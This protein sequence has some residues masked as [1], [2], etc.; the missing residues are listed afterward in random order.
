[1]VL[2]SERYRKRELGTLDCFEMNSSGTISW[3]EVADAATTMFRVW[4]SGGE[5][6]WAK[7]C[8]MHFEKAGLTSGADVV[9][10]T[11]SYLRLVAL[12]HIYEE[13]SSYMWDENPGT[14]LSDLAEDLEINAIALGVI[15]SRDPGFECDRIDDD[16]TLHEHVLAAVIDQLRPEIHCCLIEAYG[17]E[18]ALYSRMAKTTENTES[19]NS[20]EEFSPTG[21]HVRAWSFVSNAFQAP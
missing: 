5:L 19:G 3:D 1:M 17:G 4:A 15:A 20:F 13:F 12:A 21:P 6:E 18:G 14:T 2:N 9:E 7:E 10:T 11:K 8:W 16:G